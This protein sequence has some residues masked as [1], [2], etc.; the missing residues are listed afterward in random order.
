MPRPESD[1]ELLPH[2]AEAARIA[3]NERVFPKGTLV[4][5]VT[6]DYHFLEFEIL[7]KGPSQEEHLMTLIRSEPPIYEN[8]LHEKEVYVDDDILAKDRELRLSSAFPILTQTAFRVLALE[9][10]IKDRNM[11]FQ[12][13]I[14]SDLKTNVSQQ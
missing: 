11:P 4:N 3:P 6:T 7:P 9:A 12:E 5:I 1:Y 8:E 14:P 10:N 13:M 2:F